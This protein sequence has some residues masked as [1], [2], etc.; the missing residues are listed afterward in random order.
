MGKDE[1]LTMAK[2][3]YNRMREEM[4]DGGASEMSQMGTVH[5]HSASK[6]DE[7]EESPDPDQDQIR[8]ARPSAPLLGPRA[9]PGP[10]TRVE[11]GAEH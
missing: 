7:G 9:H 11:A 2:S 10:R 1:D 8:P 6:A 3:E 4:K 5:L